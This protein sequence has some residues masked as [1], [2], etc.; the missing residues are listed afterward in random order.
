[1]TT[2][3]ITSAYERDQLCAL[4]NAKEKYPFTVKI[5]E[6]RQRSNEQNKLQRMWLNEAA[7]QLA[8]YTAE[9]Y[10]AFCKLHFGVPIMRAASEEFME[11]YDR[12]IRPLPY[13][14][15][16]EYMAVPLDFPVTR[17]MTVK[18]KREYLDKMYQHFHEQ[19][20]QLTEP[21]H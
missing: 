10:R 16:L 14:V 7:N 13:E 1:M 6:G 5:T 2:R 11:K 19:G 15:K 20:V 4:L 17:A 18:Q 12:L 8:E 21:H 3:V 9:E